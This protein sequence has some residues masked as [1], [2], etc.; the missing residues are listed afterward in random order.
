MESF[1]NLAA[2]NSR[3]KEV[4][5]EERAID[6]IF[7]A[8]DITEVTVKAGEKTLTVKVSASTGMAV[9]HE[10]LLATIDTREAIEKQMGSGIPETCTTD[11]KKGGQVK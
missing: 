5:Q 7:Y 9:A 4:R 10:L 6:Q 1:I 8:A 2:L 3:L 11:C